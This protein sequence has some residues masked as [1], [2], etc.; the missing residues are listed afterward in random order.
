M[1]IPLLPLLYLDG[2]NVRKKVPKIPEANDP[3]GLFELPGSS[4]TISLITIGES[5][6]ASVG[7][8]TH[9]LGFTGSVVKT[10]CP[11]FTP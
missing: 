11:P 10:I 9:K 3:N 7:V 8:E 6:M 4:K 1:S 5:S 2:Q